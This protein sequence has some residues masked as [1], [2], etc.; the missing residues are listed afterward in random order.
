MEYYKL[1]L[2]LTACI[3]LMA[4]Y[5]RGRHAHLYTLQAGHNTPDDKPWRDKY[6]RYCCAKL[7]AS[8]GGQSYDTSLHVYMSDET[9][10]PAGGFLLTGDQLRIRSTRRAA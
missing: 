4:G 3:R 9:P 6:L 5:T 7:D 2:S 1:S 8:S 10:A